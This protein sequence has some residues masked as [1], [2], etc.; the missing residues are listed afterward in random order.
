MVLGKLAVS[1]FPSALLVSWEAADTSSLLERE[2]KV[3]PCQLLD[4][5]PS[6]KLC[7]FLP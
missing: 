5:M 2:V 1:V 4:S 7:S 6:A 3:H